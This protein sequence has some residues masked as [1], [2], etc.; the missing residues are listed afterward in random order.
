MA[1]SVSEQKVTLSM[2][3]QKGILT[4]SFCPLSKLR[5]APLKYA[6]RCKILQRAAKKLTRV[7]HY[8][9]HTSKYK[10]FDPVGRFVK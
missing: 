8:L 9:D 1:V 3:F 7:A 10:R 2:E 5:N 6:I 4:S